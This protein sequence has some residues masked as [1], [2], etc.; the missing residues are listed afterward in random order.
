M[1][2][3]FAIVLAAALMLALIPAASVMAAGDNGQ[4]DSAVSDPLIVVGAGWSATPTVPPAFFW[5]SGD[6]PVPSDSDPFTFT[7]T[8]V[9]RVDVTDD[10]CKGDQFRVYDNGEM[11]GDTSPVDVE[12][13]CSPEIGPE[14]AFNDATYSSGSFYLGPGDHSIEIVAITNPWDGGRGYIRVVQ[15][16]EFTKEITYE[17]EAGDMDNRLEPGEDWHWTI[18][19]TLTNISGETIEVEKFHDRLGGDLEWHLIIWTSKMGSL[20]DYTKGKTEKAF[21]NWY[22]G[23]TLADGE[24]VSVG[25]EVSPDVNTGTGNGKKAGHQEYTSIG[26]H[27]LNSGAW[28]GGYIGDTYIEGSSN[29]VC[30]EVLEAD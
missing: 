24:S 17:L 5:G 7:S 9:V 23:F 30:V 14:A 28:F 26:E 18:T 25:I 3:V 21:L 29:P 1:K 2:K 4:C 6:P 13:T 11:I 10:F 27:C 15:I 20:D 8:G 16:V 12:E 19:A 22:D